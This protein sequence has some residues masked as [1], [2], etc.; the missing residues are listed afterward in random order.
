M[1][2]LNMVSIGNY[3]DV[4]LQGSDKCSR[5]KLIAQSIKDAKRLLEH[6][7]KQRDEVFADS[8]QQTS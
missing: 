8:I 6:F 1:Q 4:H 3:R 7:W 2:Q 5:R